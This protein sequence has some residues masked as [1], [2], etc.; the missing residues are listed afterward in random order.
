M[1]P[2]IQRFIF[3]VLTDRNM[4]LIHFQSVRL[5]IIIN[6]CVLATVLTNSIRFSCQTNN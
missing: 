5:I 2:K 4:G 3:L 1:M 6:M